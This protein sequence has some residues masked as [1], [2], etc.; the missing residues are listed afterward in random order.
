MLTLAII[1][2]SQKPR[3]AR[4]GLWSCVAPPTLGSTRILLEGQ[5]A[6]SVARPW[7]M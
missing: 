3:G 6:A 4:P 5:C 2:S 7:K 1:A